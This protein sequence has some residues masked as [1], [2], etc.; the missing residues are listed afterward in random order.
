MP[1]TRRRGEED[2]IVTSEPTTTPLA[3]EMEPWRTSLMG[4]GEEDDPVTLG[5]AGEE[6]FYST[7]AI[8]EEDAATAS[9]DGESPFGGF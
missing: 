8:G 6:G 9:A 1:T 2:P 7:D 3:E 5:Q 4:G